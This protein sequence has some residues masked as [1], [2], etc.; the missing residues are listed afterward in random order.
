MNDEGVGIAGWLL[1]DLVLVLAIVFLA[2]TPAA[3]SD[4]SAKPTPTPEPTVA[5]PVIDRIGCEKDDQEDGSIAVLCEPE[6]SGGD[7]GTYRWEAERGWARRWT[8]GDSFSASFGGAGAVDLTVTN[9]GGEHSA[10]FPVLPPPVRSPEGSEVLTDFRFD[11]IVLEGMAINK[12]TWERT[13]KIEGIAESQTIRQDLKKGQEDVKKSEWCPQESESGCPTMDTTV[14]DFL[15]DKYDMGL[16]IALVE[17]FAHA[18]TDGGHV[19]LARA[20]N[21]AFFEGITAKPEDGGMGME[22]LFIACQSA[23]EDWFADYLDR[24][25]LGEGEVR[26]NVFFVTP[27]S[28]TGCE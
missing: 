3:L 11:Q 1:A 20:V 19:K 13:E 18:P 12:V 9:A 8:G 27:S 4:D 22:D 16:R 21:D 25:A 14:R 24:V 23:R 5:P 15:Q 2:F 10:A 28:Y 17:T 26:I 6:L 7:V